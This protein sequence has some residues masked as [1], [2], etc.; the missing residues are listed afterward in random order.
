MDQP[1]AGY[2]VSVW[3][4]P[5]IGEATFFV[6]VETADGEPPRQ[7]PTVNLWTEPTN[8]RLA[9][10]F[11]QATRQSLRNRVQ[12]KVQPHFDQRDM[13]HIGIGLTTPAGRS[14]ELTTQ[15]ESTPPGFGLWGLVIYV[16]P[17]LLLG[18][19][20]V[21]AMRRRR[22]LAIAHERYNTM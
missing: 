20:W 3:A 8:G 9:R 14:Q 10:A 1:A 22:Q 17:F 18:G 15:V 4:D 12:Y 5:D 2:V 19:F 11:Y 7:V 13:W 6:I 16:S 21:M